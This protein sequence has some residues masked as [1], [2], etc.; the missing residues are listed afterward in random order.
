M[1]W[2]VQIQYIDFKKDSHHICDKQLSWGQDLEAKAVI[3]GAQQERRHNE[4]FKI[5][6]GR[7]P[8]TNELNKHLLKTYYV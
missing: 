5:E 4:Y 6:I 8:W 3:T 2:N 7:T 1:V